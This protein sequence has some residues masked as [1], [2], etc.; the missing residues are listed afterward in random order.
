MKTVVWAICSFFIFGWT[1]GAFTRPM[2]TFAKSTLLW[3]WLA[4]LGAF[5][6]GYSVYNLLWFM[7]LAVYCGMKAHLAFLTEESL[8]PIAIHYFLLSGMFLGPA[9]LVTY[10]V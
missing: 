4:A 3:W 5:M 6:G 8:E 9:L 2:P 1:L 10:F 7:P